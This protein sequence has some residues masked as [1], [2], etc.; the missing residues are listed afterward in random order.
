[1]MVICRFAGVDERDLQNLL[2]GMALNTDD[3]KPRWKWTKNG[4]FTICNIC[5]TNIF[6]IMT[7]T[8]PSNVFEKLKFLLKIKF[9]LVMADLS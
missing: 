7:S 8:I 3:D 5:T 9:G 1:M 4:Q 6:A 2:F